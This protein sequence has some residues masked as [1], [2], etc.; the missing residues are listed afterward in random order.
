[1]HG[2]K[3]I[4]SDRYVIESKD[5]TYHLFITGIVEEDEGTYIC[6]INSVPMQNNVK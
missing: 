6:Q 2:Q 1:M 5:G 4:Q 3:V